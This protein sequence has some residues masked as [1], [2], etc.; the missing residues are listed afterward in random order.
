M[1]GLLL[2]TATFMAQTTTGGVPAGI[3]TVDAAI[4]TIG[5][6]GY[7]KARDGRNGFTCLISRQHRA[8]LEPECFD[9]EGTA[10]VVFRFAVRCSRF[11]FAVCSSR[12]TGS[13]FRSR[14]AVAPRTSSLAART[15]SLAFRASRVDP[16]VR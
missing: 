9:A 3:R 1:I 11:G 2:T 10:T 13:R 12:F 14:F 4:F 7:T 8:V 5:P 16:S 6:K 15:S